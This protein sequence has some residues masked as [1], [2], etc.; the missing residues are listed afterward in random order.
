MT[1]FDSRE[2]AFEA[3]YAHDEETRFLVT[4]RRDKLFA[5][6]LA[7]QAHVPDEPLVKT[8]LAI[9]NGPGHDEAVLKLASD[10]LSSHGHSAEPAEL[11]QAL[12]ASG[13]QA[14]EQFLKEQPSA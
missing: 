13:K 2:Q 5:H 12:T 8:I 10:T 7:G 3:K 9:A 14:V 11:Q 6:W 1:T 4:A